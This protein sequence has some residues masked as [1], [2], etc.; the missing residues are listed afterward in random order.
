MKTGQGGYRVHPERIK[1]KKGKR[2]KGTLGN[3]D[4][5]VEKE[6]GMEQAGQVWQ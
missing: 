4:Q 5:D 3:G 1:N 2:Q 6:P